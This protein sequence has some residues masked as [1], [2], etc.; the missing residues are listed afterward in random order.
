MS[1]DVASFTQ[2]YGN[3]REILFKIRSNNKL[4][5]K[6]R[7]E[8]ALNIFSFHNSDDEYIK[9]VSEKYLVP[10]YKN[11]IVVSQKNMEYTECVRNVLEIVK[12]KKIKSFFFCQD[13][14][15]CV[16]PSFDYL[17]SAFDLYHQHDLKHLHLDN[18]CKT[19]ESSCDKERF[20]QKNGLNLWYNSLQ[21]TY[22]VSGESMM[23]DS[24][25]VADIDFLTDVIYD[26]NYFNIGAVHPAESYIYTKVYEKDA[27]RWQV[28][29]PLWH[30]I[31]V[32][33]PN[34]MK[35]YTHEKIV[36]DL[37]LFLGSRY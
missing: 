26:D 28:E 34:S 10:H 9:M 30:N 35:W 22:D 13:D 27:P 16:S 12:G 11:L 1:Y 4:D 21:R 25:F 31:N 3:E 5:H 18:E 2:T 37:L 32:V 6:M 8:F 7:N 17:K 14:G 33:G 20:F 29:V 23:N 36:D 19:V 24:P 15:F